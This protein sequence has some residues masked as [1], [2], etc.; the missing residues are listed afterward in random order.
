LLVIDQVDQLC[1]GCLV[2][3]HKRAPFPKQLEYRDED[4]LALVHG[5]ICGPITLTTPSGNWYF[6]LLVDDVS[7][8]MWVK[9]LATRDRAT[10]AIKQYQATAEAGIDR[11]LKVF[12]SD[13]GGEFT[14]A[15]FANHCVQYGVRRQLTTPYTPQ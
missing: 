2:G 3:K 8:F 6:I 12:Q 15:E 10:D 13:H 11:K 7:R 14:S 9:M 4:V 5:D 1:I